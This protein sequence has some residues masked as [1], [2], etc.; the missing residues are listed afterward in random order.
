MTIE[1]G[2]APQRAVLEVRSRIQLDVLPESNRVNLDPAMMTS[3]IESS[4]APQYPS[5]RRQPSGGAGQY[6][7]EAEPQLVSLAG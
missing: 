4:R 1:A 3:G 6:F 7:L 5:V 2:S